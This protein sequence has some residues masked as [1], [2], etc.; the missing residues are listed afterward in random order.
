MPVKGATGKTKPLKKGMGLYDVQH[1]PGKAPDKSKPWAVVNLSTGDIA[2]RWHPNEAS[3]K[4]QQRALYARL[5]KKARFGMSEVDNFITPIAFAELKDDIL[6]LEALP[7]KTWHTIMYGEVAVTNEKLQN[8]IANFRSNVRG[9]KIATDYDHG[10]DRSKGNKASGWIEDLDV[11]G[12]SL[13]AGIKLTPT[14]K[15]EIEADEWKYFSLEWE[16]KWMHPETQ[17][18]HQDV[19]IGGGFTN[20]P[21][22]KG[23]VPINFSEIYEE[24]KEFT[25]EHAAEE[26]REPGEEPDFTLNQDDSFPDRRHTDPQLNDDDPERKTSNSKEGTVGTD[27]TVPNE[28]DVQLRKLLN[29]D[30]DADIVKAVTDL[31]EEVGPLREVAKQFSERKKFAEMFPKEAAELEE[32]RKERIN[33][34][35]TKFAETIGTKE[36]VDGKSL[37]AK[38]LEA[39][40][41]VHKAF[42]EGTATI[43]QFEEFISSLTEDGGLVE[44]GERGSSSVDTSALKLSEGANP[45]IAFAETVKAIMEQDELSYDAAVVEA[46]KRNPEL[47]AAYAAPVRA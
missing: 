29:L 41:N 11:R 2:G 36:I 34:A 8:M 12:E 4:D 26:H 45:R 35:S 9:Q 30:A 42:S 10:M 22:A 28:T 18:V 21:V 40:A 44:L 31:N 16:D 1:L 19:I 15:Q 37:S 47:A 46:A 13:W 33:N 14:A 27:T 38:S 6:W 17:E 20:R 39:V 32:A 25:N 24:K 23:L 43:E 3:A 7:A 5:G